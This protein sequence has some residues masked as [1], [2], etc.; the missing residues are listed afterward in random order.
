[1]FESELIKQ[2][3]KYQVKDNNECFYLKFFK[4][5]RYKDGDGYFFKSNGE[6]WSLLRKEDK[7]GRVFFNLENNE[8]YDGSLEIF[9]D[10]A[11]DGLTWFPDVKAWLPAALVHDALIQ[12]CDEFGLDNSHRVLAHKEMGAMIGGW[13]GEAV[14]Y[15][16]RLFHP[17]YKLFKKYV[18]EK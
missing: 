17:F 16:L 9:E 15:G 8:G 4:F 12:I 18:G 1:M 11:F 3:W 13:Q 7:T 2:N 14:E 6:G 5:S 10:Y